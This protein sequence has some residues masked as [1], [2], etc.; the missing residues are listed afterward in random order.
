VAETRIP[1]GFHVASKRY[2]DVRD[3]PS[4]AKC[5]CMCPGCELPLIARHCMVGRVDH[6]AH[7]TRGQNKGVFKECTFSYWVSLAA[8]ARQILTEGPTIDLS[9]PEYSYTPRT[10]WDR[11]SDDRFVCS[12]AQTITLGDVATGKIM[13]GETFDVI[14]VSKGVPVCIKLLHPEKM[15]APD[16]S[17]WEYNHHRAVVFLIDISSATNGFQQSEV[18]LKEVL[19]NFLRNDTENKEWLYHPRMAH[20]LEAIRQQ[21]EADI[22]GEPLR[23][24]HSQSPTNVPIS[25][26][27]KTIKAGQSQ[28]YRSLKNEYLFYCRRCNHQILR[29]AKQ[30]F[31]DKC[32]G[33]MYRIHSYQAS[34]RA[35]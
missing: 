12:K 32:S 33:V 21:K 22:V 27:P 10:P 35:T 7:N 17:D 9:L 15:G 5:G 8:M 26:S 34:L 6:F 4:G 3:V 23:A 29:N 31:C 16:L 1:F 19:A 25:H 13:S 30:C 28:L 11:D 20:K 2:V 24:L 18:P 14:G